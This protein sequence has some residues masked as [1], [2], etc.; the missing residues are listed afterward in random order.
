VD[1]LRADGLCQVDAGT[2][3]AI[4]SGE[5]VPGFLDEVTDQPDP[6]RGGGDQE[7]GVLALAERRLQALVV[8]LEVPDHRQFVEPD[9]AQ[10]LPADRLRFLGGEPADLRAVGKLYLL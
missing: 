3:A 1:V 4:R 5:L 8:E 9:E 6:L 2:L 7:P 10:V